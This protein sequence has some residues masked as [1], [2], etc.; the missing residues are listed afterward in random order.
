M[1][2]QEL[3]LNAVLV[4]KVQQQ[5]LIDMRVSPELYNSTMIKLYEDMFKQFEIY[6]DNH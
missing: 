6:L 1:N 3:I 2:L 4:A 5:S